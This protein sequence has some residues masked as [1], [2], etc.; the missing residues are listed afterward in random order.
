MEIYIRDDNLLQW[1]IMVTFDKSW[2]IRVN[3]TQQDLSKMCVLTTNVDQSSFN[4]H[5]LK[6]KTLI[7]L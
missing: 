3:C 5:D 4:S 2:G 1:L 6:W 7:A